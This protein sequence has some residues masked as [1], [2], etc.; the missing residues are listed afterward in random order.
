M[1]EQ[2]AYIAREAQALHDAIARGD[3]DD[4]AD[5]AVCQFQKSTAHDGK[6]PGDSAGDF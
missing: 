5:T 2:S 1:T 3:L 4:A 6:T